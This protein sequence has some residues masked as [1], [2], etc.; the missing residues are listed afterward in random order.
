[1]PKV[2]NIN[3]PFYQY[4]GH[5][6]L[7]GYKEYYGMPTGHREL[8]SL[9]RP[10]FLQVFLEKDFGEKNIVVLCLDVTKFN[11]GRLFAGK[12][13]LNTERVPPRPWASHNSP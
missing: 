7:I 2:S 12:A 9:F 11:N 5:I 6:E 3:R 1:M 13:C 4:G 10:I 8:L